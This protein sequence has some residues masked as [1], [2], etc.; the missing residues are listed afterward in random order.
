MIKKMNKRGVFFTILVIAILSLF[1]VSYSAISLVKNRESIN[2]RIDS[3][4]NFVQLVE[5]DM[6]RKL[7]I[8]SFRVIF[9]LLNRVIKNGTYIDDVNFRF[10]ETFFNGSVYGE[11]QPVNMT[12]GVIYSEILEDLNEKASKVNINVTMINPKME[13]SQED[14][15]NVRVFF[16]ANLLI[17]DRSNLA[18][19]N[20]Y[21]SQIVYVPI[22]NFEDPIYIVETNSSVSNSINK[23]IYDSFYDPGDTSNLSGHITNGY[24][25]ASTSGPSFL[26]RF[27]GNLSARSPYGIESLVNL[28]ELESQGIPTFQ[29]SIVDYIYF[30]E[31]DNPASCRI[32]GM[33][34]WVRL[35][36]EDD[37]WDIYNVTGFTIC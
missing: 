12:E 28:N 25:I 21:F 16:S 17:E 14:P 18:T 22:E 19:W 7:Y 15:W 34:S 37:H 20:R 33:L 13:I 27:E 23:T 24:Y 10:N 2:K 26:D 8:S 35:D 5:E 3:M 32:T 6:P 4:N 36:D 29:K 1:L 9:L 31:T 30:N 11:L